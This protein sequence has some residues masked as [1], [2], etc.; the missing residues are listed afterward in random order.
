MKGTKLLIFLFLA[1]T[2]IIVSCDKDETTT[3]S[4][5]LGKWK[6]TGKTIDASAVNLTNCEGLSRLELYEKNLCLIADS[7]QHKVIR[8]GWSYKYDMLNI[9]YDLPAAYYVETVNSTTLQ[10]KRKDFSAL[11]NLQITILNYS[12][13]T[14]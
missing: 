6:L 2:G 8:S 11:G 4:L 14:D 9:A 7:C 10:L 5:L 12:K 3:E 1:I 13:A